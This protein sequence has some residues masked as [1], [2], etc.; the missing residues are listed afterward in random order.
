M[1]I[2]HTHTG[3]HTHTH[4][5]RPPQGGPPGAP[6]GPPGAP[7]GPRG[8]PRTHPQPIQTHI[9]PRAATKPHSRHFFNYFGQHFRTIFQNSQSQNHKLPISQHSAFGHSGAFAS[10]PPRKV[11][12][13]RSNFSSNG[14]TA[15]PTKTIPSKKGVWGAFFNITLFPILEGGFYVC[16]VFCRTGHLEGYIVL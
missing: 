9:S 7:G 8:T 15:T 14:Q 13:T 16:Y 1:R 12:A 4:S 6:R 3:E 10:H 11:N 2:T 5:P